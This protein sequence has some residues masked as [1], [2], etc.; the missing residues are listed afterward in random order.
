M[1]PMHRKR[2]ACQSAWPEFGELRAWMIARL[3]WD[4]TLDGEDLLRE[5]CD[6]YYGDASQQGYEAASRDKLYL[7]LENDEFYLL[8][9]DYN[10]D[11][12]GAGLTSYNE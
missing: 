3:L 10:T 1:I 12:S 5:F 8:F 6:G 4:P 11:L 9:G 7:K 2:M